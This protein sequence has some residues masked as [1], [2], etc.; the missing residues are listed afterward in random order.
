MTTLFYLIFGAKLVRVSF[1][2]SPFTS[3]YM[4]TVLTFSD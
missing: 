3:S 4:A 2:L 1:T